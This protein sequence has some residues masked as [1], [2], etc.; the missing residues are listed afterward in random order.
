MNASLQCLRRINEFKDT[1]SKY[2]AGNGGDGGSRFTSSFQR[3]I[4]SLENKGEAYEP[5]EFF[6]VSLKVSQSINC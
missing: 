1:V 2:K 5:I 4:G 6:T 3:L